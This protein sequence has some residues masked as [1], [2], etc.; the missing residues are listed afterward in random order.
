MENV[1]RRRDVSKRRRRVSDGRH[2]DLL[3]AAI[4]HPIWQPRVILTARGG[5][6]SSVLLPFDRSDFIYYSLDT[7]EV[8]V[9]IIVLCFY[10]A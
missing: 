9:K 5:E 4:Y 10:N 8:V 1:F 6:I 7:V 2:V 3:T